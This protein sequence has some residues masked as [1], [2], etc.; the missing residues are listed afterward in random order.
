MDK[1]KPR[2][3][4]KVKRKLE[5]VSDHLK[6]QNETLKKMLE[7]LSEEGIEKIKDPNDTE[8]Q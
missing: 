2:K 6:V 4:D 8:T 1:E 5:K 7:K 3:P